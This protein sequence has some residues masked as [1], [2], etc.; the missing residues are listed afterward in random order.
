MYRLREVDGF[1]DEISDLI[2]DLHRRTFADSAPAVVPDYGHWW[3]VYCGDLPC[4]FAGLTPSTLGEGIGYLKRAGVLREHRG[5]GLQRRLIT[6]RERRARLNGWCRIVTDTTDN[7]ASANS[8]IGCG[9]RLFEPVH[10]W[11]YAQTLYWSKA[12]AA[13]VKQLAVGHDVSKEQEG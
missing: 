10:P 11:G 4:G 13:P 7:I 12:L 3:L 5:N 1:D 2:I 8:L 6:A 9:Y